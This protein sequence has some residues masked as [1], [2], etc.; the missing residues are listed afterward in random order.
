MKGFCIPTEITQ[1]TPFVPAAITYKIGETFEFSTLLTNWTTIPENCNI[2]Y[3]YLIKSSSGP[4]VDPDMIVASLDLT[5]M[6]V[7]VGTNQIHYGGDSQSG[8]YNPGTYIVEV[9]A[10][11]ENNV[12]TEKFEELTIIIE[13][14]CT[15]AA[16]TIDDSVLKPL[17]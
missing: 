15:T 17:S 5:Y 4:V 16:L 1:I 10:W 14:T 13:D 7:T 12:D 2:E 8:T 11:A 9:R 6:Q 3:R